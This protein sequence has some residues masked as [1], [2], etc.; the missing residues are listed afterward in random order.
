M[1]DTQAIELI[2][3]FLGGTATPEERQLLERWYEE[4]DASALAFETTSQG[5]A[6][7]MRRSLA[8]I[9]EKI[10]RESG[11]GEPV[12]SMKRRRR[13]P[14]RWA[15]AAAVLILAGVAGYFLSGPRQQAAP[16]EIVSSHQDIRPGSRKAV[17]TLGNG[18]SI[19]LDSLRQGVLSRQGNT[20]V[21][22]VKRGLL[23]YASQRQ[24]AGQT[25]DVQYNTVTTP[26]GGQYQ[27]VLADGSRVWLNSSS[28][29]RFPTRFTGAG[30]EVS[31]T[32]EVYFEIAPNRGIPFVVKAGKV[33]VQVLGTHFNVMA[34]PDEPAVKTTLL[35]GSVKVARGAGT[36][37]LKPGQQADVNAE[38]A[39]KL[40]TDVNT[41]EIIAWKNNLF[42]FDGNDIREVMNALA[43]W[44]DVDIDITGN[45]PD[46]FTG[47]IP[48][49]LPFSKVF[50]MLQQT[51]RINYR[52]VGDK[53]I[54][55][56]P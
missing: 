17:L 52:I 41:D 37:V 4:F 18:R 25:K 20:S 7:S 36:L 6:D 24:S 2:T 34:Y 28:S 23:T 9:R 26:R 8:A 44:Y 32:G 13:S 5:Q 10:A 47:S 21:V 55:V 39:M 48:M 43:R 19:A 27:I 49:D 46:R 1:T 3:K 40:V 53:K 56:S 15:A 16:R 14:Y 45:I 11:T 29:I 22:K 38:G 54:I 50:G 33:S 35:E 30:R 42:W 12:L 31:V 51:G